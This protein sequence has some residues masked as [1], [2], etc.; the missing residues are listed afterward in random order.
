MAGVW[1]AA[2]VGSMVCHLQLLLPFMFIIDYGVSLTWMRS[3]FKGALTETTKLATHAC[4][5]ADISHI[6]T[7]NERR[8]IALKLR[9]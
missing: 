8:K 5:Y 2:S 4:T 3:L 9:A 7:V 1:G 6:N